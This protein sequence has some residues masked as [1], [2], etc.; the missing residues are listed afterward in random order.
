MT[1]L[2]AAVL[3]PPLI[4]PI[5]FQPRLNFFPPKPLKAFF[6]LSAGLGPL[7]IDAFFNPGALSHFFGP[8]GPSG[9]L[10][11]RLILNQAARMVFGE[12]AESFLSHHRVFED[13]R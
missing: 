4:V 13:L 5:F 11:A 7:F 1:T 6:Q 2:L 8:T 12:L 9:F 3:D 10:G